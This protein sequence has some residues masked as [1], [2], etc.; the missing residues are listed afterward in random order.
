MPRGKLL[1]KEEKGSIMKLKCKGNSIDDIATA[2]EGS[3]KVLWTFIQ[4]SERYGKTRKSERPSKLSALN[5]RTLLRE[6]HVGENSVGQLCQYLHL[7]IG[8]I[9]RSANHAQHGDIEVQEVQ[10]GTVADN[11]A[12]RPLLELRHGVCSTQGH[13]VPQTCFLGRE[14]FNLDGLDGL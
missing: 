3:T 2:L 1:I 10:K 9:A 6:A 13:R 14:K 11:C 12:K 5:R 4:A 7:P 8:K